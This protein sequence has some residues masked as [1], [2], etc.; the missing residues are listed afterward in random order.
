MCTGSKECEAAANAVMQAANQLGQRAQPTDFKQVRWISF[1][2]F[3]LFLKKQKT[4]QTII[5]PKLKT[6]FKLLI[7]IKIQ[8]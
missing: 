7:S 1:N 8:K 4:Q 2:S 6:I 5:K 3:N